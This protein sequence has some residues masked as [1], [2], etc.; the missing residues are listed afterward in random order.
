M[1]V[2]GHAEQK[3]D[4]EGKEISG[5]TQ[6]GRR[7]GHMNWMNREKKTGRENRFTAAT[8]NVLLFASC[9]S[10]WLLNYNTSA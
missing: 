10:H 5:V 8:V 6:V 1:A 9:A 4:F 2:N 7:R 3:G